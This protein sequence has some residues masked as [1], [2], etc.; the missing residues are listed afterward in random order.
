MLRFRYGVVAAILVLQG[1][2]ASAAGDRE[3]IDLSGAGWTLWQDTKAAWEKDE[4]FLPPVDLS[5]LPVN[6]PSGGW[7]QL[8]RAPEKI[9]VSVPGTVEGYLGNGKGAG[10]DIKGVSW[11]CRTIQIPGDPAPR[12]FILRFESVRLRA[13]VFIDRKL[14]GYDLIGNTPFEVDIT[15]HVKPGQRVRLALRI[16]DPGGNFS[17][18]DCDPIFQWGKYNIPLSHG[19]GGITGRVRLLSVADVFR[20]TRRIYLRRQGS[21]CHGDEPRETAQDGE[22]RQESSVPGDLQYDQ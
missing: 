10:S 4:L 6:F 21:F 8:D 20:G 15:D 11:W 7:D 2:I 18:V 1:M 16:T 13:E 14:V 5:R 12:R 9:A 3:E 22:A 17:W 19:F